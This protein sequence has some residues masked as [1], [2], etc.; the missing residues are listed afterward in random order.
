M[1][2]TNRTITA[3]DLYK[4]EL[5]SAMQISPD[6][7]NVIYAQPR[8]DP[9]TEKKYSNLWVISTGG[10]EPRQFTRGDQVDA[11]PKY[12]PD[13]SQIAFLSNRGD[14]KQPQI[15]LIPLNGGEAHPLTDLK[16][17]F[18]SF[19]WSPDGERLV[20][21]FRAKD[22]EAIEREEDEKKKELGVVA[23]HID[24][25]RYKLDGYG[26]LPKERWHIW[27]VNV[28]SGDATQLT[29]GNIYDETAPAWSPDGDWI[30]CTS[31]R[32][33]DPDM[34][35]DATDLFAIPSAGGEM[36]K[37]ETPIGAKQLP[38]FSPDGKWIAYFGSEGLN[39]WWKNS[40][41]WVVPFDNSAPARNLTGQFDFHIGQ[42]TI[43]DVNG[44][45][46]A[47]AAPTWS[48]GGQQIYFQVSRHGINTLHTI[49]TDG[50]NLQTVIEGQGVVGTYSFDTAHQRLAY[51]WGTMTSPGQIWVRDLVNVES[52]QITHTNSWLDEVNLGEIEETWFTGRDG[53]DLQGWI[54]KPPG[55]DPSQNYPS[56]L[57][58]HGGPM[59]QYGEF[60]MHE[61]YYLAA[62]GYVVYFTN[63]RGGQGYGEAHTKAISGNWGDA[64]YADLMLWAD[65]ISAQPYIDTERMGVTGGSYGGYMSLWIIGHTH[66]FKAAAAQRVVSN[67]IS[68]WGTSDMNWLS[69]V[70]VGD[71]APIDDIETA[72]DHS[73]V[74]YLG[75]A[76]TPTLIIH[77]EN[78]N[79]CP[80][81]QG[82][83]A[84]VTLKVKGVD[85]EMVLFPGEPHGLSR[86]GRTDRRIVRLQHI[87]RW[88]DRYLK[89]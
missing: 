37:I 89:V 51:F 48:P 31:N 56:I 63:P 17:E 33:P 45:A 88:M 87:A 25:L 75:N 18:D 23:R 39:V 26:F 13:G 27:T 77:S 30:V 81:E 8:V 19:E 52:R 82:E 6:G 16:G 67:F 70:L 59:A 9:K 50:G 73:P 79:R 64:D 76:T 36:R 80:I 68:M 58:I 60:F 32:Q 62:Q 24:R 12:S 65:H 11:S 3:E 71:R 86:M 78:D 83:Q 41:L 43:N 28:H 53:N 54:L 42:D 5:I 69:Q 38:R 84:F 40:N 72:W 35:P 44:G 2:H 22:A 85:T 61:F 15:Y 7:Q 49:D 14:E 66:Q 46:A 74:K 34:T 20:C 57:E 29:E 4:F 10:G 47:L 55:F 21:Q 1:T